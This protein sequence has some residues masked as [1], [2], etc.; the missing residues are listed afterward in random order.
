MKRI[1]FFLSIP[2]LFMGAGCTSDIGSEAPSSNLPGQNVFACDTSDATCTVLGVI[3]AEGEITKLYLE[4]NRAR[5]VSSMDC[6]SGYCLVT[7]DHGTEW[8][9][10][11]DL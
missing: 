5:N 7:D 4:P 3:V 1:M 2:L 10:E 8:E 6:V 11:V 9:M